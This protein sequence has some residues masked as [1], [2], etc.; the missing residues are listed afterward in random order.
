MFC[1]ILLLCFVLIYESL[2]TYET[3]Q[4]EALN[5]SHRRASESFQT[6]DREFLGPMDN[7]FQRYDSFKA[8][9][10]EL[11]KLLRVSLLFILK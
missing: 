5:P 4:M 11:V 8:S 1:D 2:F 3:F 9:G 7:G 10:L 6:F